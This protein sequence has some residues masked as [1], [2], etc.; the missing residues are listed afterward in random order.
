MNET[1]LEPIILDV[2]LTEEESEFDILDG[3]SLEFELAGSE[4][5]ILDADLTEEEHDLEMTEE[6]SVDLDLSVSFLIAGEHYEGNY[7]V[8]PSSEEQV[9]ATRDKV[10]DQDVVVC[11]IPSNYGL[12]TWNGAVLTVS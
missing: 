10:M 8:E 6:E 12:I 5:I 11:P 7:V 3:E 4:P 9:L 1:A 2:E